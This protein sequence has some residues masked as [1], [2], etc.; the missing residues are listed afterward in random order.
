MLNLLSVLILTARA[1]DAVKVLVSRVAP[2]DAASREEATRL[3]GVLTDAVE[4][5]DGLAVVRVDDTP[6]WPDYSA[7]TYLQGCRTEDLAA[8]A[9][10]VAQRGGARLAV[11]ARVDVDG[12]ATVEIEVVDV[13][14]GRVVVA[15]ET[16]VPEGQER[17]FAEGVAK[18][19]RAAANG[20]FE[21]QDLRPG[22]TRASQAEEEKTR[23]AAVAAQLAALSKDLG[24]AE[25]RPT[26]KV[27][28]AALTSDELAR[29]TG[30]DTGTAPWERLG[31][32]SEAYLRYKNSGMS[33]PEWR[34]RA[35]GRAGQVLVRPWLGMMSGPF[36]G[37]YVGR[38][39]Y[40]SQL[41]VVDSLSTQALQSATSGAVGV[42]AA[43]GLLPVLDIGVVA[44]V[45]TGTYS[46]DI[47]QQTVGAPNGV[48]PSYTRTGAAWV[49]G[50]RVAFAPLPTR[51][52]RPVVGASVLAIGAQGV[53]S[54]ITPPP[55][56]TSWEAPL[57]WSV[58]ALAGV[59]A[60]VGERV[61]LYA[62]LPVNLVVAG[63]LRESTRTGTLTVVEDAPP[64][65]ASSV[66]GGLQ[67]GIQVR[68][69]GRAPVRTD[70]VEEAEDAAF[71]EGP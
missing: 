57:L 70:R 44:G 27:E 60:R 37:A 42:G 23:D 22:D 55:E 41:Q 5:A 26:R 4:R 34:M 64:A 18:V 19:I 48:E 51:N 54:L 40:D 12:D 68:F 58:E 31:M 53:R 1:D 10:V 46:I 45:T 61:D 56:L 33:L 43:W 20:D 3:E 59:E 29:R 28:R 24:P 9:L 14:E 30:G 25:I 38:F 50:P 71:D 21:A 8:C 49:A 13:A 16:A 39:A 36:G 63:A 17:L 62:H 15:F 11:S 66:G 52:V 65:E 32:S 7:R 47:D 69:G 2:S 67:L 35:Q 6:A